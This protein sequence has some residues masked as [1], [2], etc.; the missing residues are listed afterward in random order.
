M[1]NPDPLYTYEDVQTSIVDAT[2]KY[3]YREFNTINTMRDSQMDIRNW[4]LTSEARAIYPNASFIVYDFLTGRYENT[5]KDLNSGK[6]TK[7]QVY[8]ILG[9]IHKFRAL[10]TSVILNYTKRIKIVGVDM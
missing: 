8:R 9:K 2:V 5:I 6:I 7:K 3:A 1:R 4:A 10:P